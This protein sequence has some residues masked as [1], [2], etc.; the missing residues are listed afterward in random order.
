MTYALDSAEELMAEL[1][2]LIMLTRTVRKLSVEDLSKARQSS[3]A[4]I[5]RRGD[6]ARRVGPRR[7]SLDVFADRPSPALR[8]RHHG[9]VQA[10]TDQLGRH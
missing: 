10:A 2:R 3:V 7:R 4:E 6:R 9:G 8:R 1:G 5:E